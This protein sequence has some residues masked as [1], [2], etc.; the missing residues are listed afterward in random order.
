MRTSSMQVTKCCPI[1]AAGMYVEVR[2]TRY[3]KNASSKRRYRSIAE[4][5]T[6]LRDGTT[7]VNGS[8]KRK[9]RSSRPQIAHT[10]NAV[11]AMAA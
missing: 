10:R 6:M 4:G 3:Y 1:G 9:G 11:K 5:R 2:Q 7:K 8:T